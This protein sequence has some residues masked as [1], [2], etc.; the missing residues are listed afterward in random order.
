MTPRTILLLGSFDTKAAEYGLVRDLI[1]ARG[2][3]TIL[4]DLGVLPGEPGFPVDIPA[5]AVAEA[6]GQ[7]LTALREARDRGV[8]VGVM[9]AGAVVLVRA[10]HQ[11]G[12]FDG[13]L[14]L[15]G[16]GGTTMIT[17]AMR[18]L[19]VGLPKVMVSTMASGNTAPYVDIKDITMMYPVVDI[20]G[21]N[22]LSRRILANAAGAVCGMVEQSVPL[23]SG[24][25]LLGASMFGVTTPCVTA[26]RQRL[27]AA[28]YDVAVFHAT[29]SGG[30][31]LES[32]C[33]DGY[34]AGVLD[35][36]TTEWAD[37]VVG[38]VLSAGPDRLRAAGQ[39]GLPQVVSVGALDMVN[40][41]A[42]ETVPARFADR[43]FYHHNATVTLMR[44]TVEECRIIG[45][46]VAEQLNAAR[47]PV[48]VVL[49]L[50]GIS[51]IDQAGQPF[52]DPAADE[53][54]FHAL[55][56]TLSP[57]IPCQCLD[58]HINDPAFAD[59]LA[60]TLLSFLR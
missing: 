6:G 11:A 35:V 49:P 2:H 58:L 27:E 8:A 3:R 14:G 39:R 16:G 38:G 55:R 28:G 40:F 12:G 22:P 53:A 4:M 48:A 51:M 9:Q 41:G 52:H 57:T 42:P 7:R 31:A 26:A 34:L 47:G 21:L 23:V 45:R 44:T 19:P 33:E 17:A 54:L 32:L 25:P 59:A 43:T 29:G 5:E 30:R 18:S 36:T 15:G 56:D 37:E 60:D 13:I 10:L 20:A 1:H 24:R 46:R 50:R